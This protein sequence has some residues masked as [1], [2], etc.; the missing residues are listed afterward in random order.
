MTPD[1]ATL[2]GY[3]RLHQRPPAFGGSDGR[4]YSV[5]ILVDDTPDGA[6]RFGAGI[7]FVRWSPSGDAPDGH[8]E[9]DWLVFGATQA[10][11]KRAVQAMTLQEIKDHLD[12]A[13]RAR[14]QE[15]DW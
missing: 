2:G 10:E 13:V 9:T 14:Q 4:A 11:A 8:V 1:D 12:R 6:G 7:L 15:P 3:Q 5:G